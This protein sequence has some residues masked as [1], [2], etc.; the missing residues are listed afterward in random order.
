MIRLWLELADW[1]FRMT[2]LA[3]TVLMALGVGG[4]DTD[5]KGELR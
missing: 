4:P 3:K 5:G 2:L 1:W